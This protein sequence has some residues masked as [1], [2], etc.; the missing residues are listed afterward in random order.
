MRRAEK[1][2]AMAGKD[3]T[4][5]NDRFISEVMASSLTPQGYNNT[6]SDTFDSSLDTDLGHQSNPEALDGQF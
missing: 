5:G 3:G 6:Q 2:A 4:A 1:S